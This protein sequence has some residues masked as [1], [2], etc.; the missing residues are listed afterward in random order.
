[1]NLRAPAPGCF[2]RGC[3]DRLACQSEE[4][5]DEGHGDAEGDGAAV[6]LGDENG[7]EKHVGGDVAWVEVEGIKKGVERNDVRKEGL[8]RSFTVHP[9]GKGNRL[10]L[11]V[12]AFVKEWSVRSCL[13]NGPGTNGLF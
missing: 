8:K 9:S 13:S 6:P 11:Q 5:E 2:W 7:L 12:A 1:M 10:A 4:K 3:L